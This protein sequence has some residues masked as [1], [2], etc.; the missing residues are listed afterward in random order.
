MEHIYKNKFFGIIIFA[1]NKKT[2]LHIKMVQASIIISLRLKKCKYK[3]IF[4]YFEFYSYQIY[5]KNNNTNDDNRKTLLRMKNN[6]KFSTYIT[7]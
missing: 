5:N 2:N 3:N 4:Q 1:E 6:M 7:K